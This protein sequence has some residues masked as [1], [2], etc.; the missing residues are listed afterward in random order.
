MLELHLMR[1]AASE[2][3]P[4]MDHPTDFF[5]SPTTIDPHQEMAQMFYVDAVFRTMIMEAFP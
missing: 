1:G 5:Y 3:A 4:R 2:R